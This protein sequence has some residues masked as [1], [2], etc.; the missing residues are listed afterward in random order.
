MGNSKGANSS[1]NKYCSLFSLTT[2]TR[3][4]DLDSHG[5]DSEEAYARQNHSDGPSSM[6]E[7]VSVWRSRGNAHNESEEE[8]TE[9]DKRVS[10]PKRIANVTTFTV[11]EDRI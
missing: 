3:Q 10:V 2:F 9:R 4:D 8:L 6:D 11:N 7:G 1:G 5:G